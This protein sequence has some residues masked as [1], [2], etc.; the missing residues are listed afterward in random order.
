MALLGRPYSRGGP[1]PKNTRISQIG[2]S[3]LFLKKKRGSKAG[4]ERGWIWEELGK[5]SGENM[6]KK[7][8]IHIKNFQSIKILCVKCHHNETFYI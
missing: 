2:P 3:G 4:K 5:K 8:Y 6:I 7:I 1:I